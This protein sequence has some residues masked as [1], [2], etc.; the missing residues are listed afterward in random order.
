M[1][2]IK[3]TFL[4]AEEPTVILGEE[5]SSDIAVRELPHDPVDQNIFIRKEFTSSEIKNWKVEKIDTI[6]DTQNATIECEITLSPLQYLPKSISEKHSSNG[7]KL[8]RGRLLECDF[9]YFSQDISLGNQPSTTI[10]NFNSKLPYEMVKRRLVVVLSNKEDPALVVPISKGNKAKDHRTV[11]GITSLPP[12]LVTFNNP[13]CFAKTAAISYVSGHRLF[14][15]RFNTDEGRR[16]Y[17]YRVEKKLSND[18]VVNIK[19]AVFTAVG[20]DNILRSIESKDEQI[21]ALNGEITI[22]NNRIKCLNAKNAE[23]WE[24]LEE[25]TK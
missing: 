23:L 22:K 12:D 6:Q 2:I 13:R 17:D 20:G 16:Q 19:K 9:G 11:V 25:Y 4:N 1:T 15:V 3:V 8:V 10:S 14:P 21:D 24:M 5:A 18:D 7:S